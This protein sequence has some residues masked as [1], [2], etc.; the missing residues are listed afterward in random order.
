[1]KMIDR[2]WARR[3]IVKKETA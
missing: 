2:Q 3:F 1:M